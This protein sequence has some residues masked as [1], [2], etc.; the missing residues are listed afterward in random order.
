MN[1][2]FGADVS[3]KELA[4]PIVA[5]VEYQGDL[6]FDTTK[7]DGT[8]KKLLDV[9]KINRIGLE[10]SIKLSEGIS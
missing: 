4:E 9:L 2:G 3:V 5:E 7:P 6:V 1:I 8:P 10:S